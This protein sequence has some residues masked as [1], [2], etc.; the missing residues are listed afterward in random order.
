M[1][2]TLVMLLAI[3]M[4]LV[5]L[6]GCDG[7]KADSTTPTGSTGVTNSGNSVSKGTSK[8]TMVIRVNSDPTSFDPY[9]SGYGNSM[10]VTKSVFETLVNKDNEGNIK[11]GLATNWE[12]SEDGMSLTFK[13]REGVVFH[14]GEIFSADD[15][16]WSLS[17]FKTQL[18]ITETIFDFEN[19]KKISDYEISIP[20]KQPA[21]D[22]L[23]RL[24]DITYAISN[25]AAVEQAGE[26]YN[27]KP[28]GTG[29]FEFVSWVQGDEA[30]LKAFDKYWDGKPKIENLIMRVIPEDSQA[31][32]E[33]ELGNVDVVLA[34]N[35]TD[36]ERV[37]NGN[38]EGAAVGSY[39]DGN[40]WNLLFNYEKEWTL[41]KKLRQAISYAI[42]KEDIVNGAYN[43]YAAV[44]NQPMSRLF[45]GAYIEE[46]DA[47]NYSTYDPEKA[48]KLLSEAG[49]SPGELNLVIVTDLDGTIIDMAQLIKKNL[50]DVGIN[51]EIR[52]YDSA[53]AVGIFIA[54]DEDDVHMN[55]TLSGNGYPIV[56]L[57]FSDPNLSPN[58]DHAAD[59][60]L[61]DEV[62]K[63]YLKA[64]SSTDR[65]ECFSYVQ[66]GV[67]IEVEETLMVP[68]VET[69]NYYLYADNLESLGYINGRDFNF[70]DAYFK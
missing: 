48:K 59:S 30:K 53:T 43:G 29:P 35:L 70:K 16:I 60:G 63:N 55:I 68:L 20:L 40:V 1:K 49:Y 11:P 64:L 19:I 66:Q 10:V 8:D 24:C 47:S 62:Y 18:N 15:V 13:L 2:R 37:K 21:G 46:Y 44:A 56:Y 23:A 17:T 27:W 50:E 67:R 65:D 9:T 36:V 7:K 52:S 31:A 32:I 4:L 22:A 33:L 61:F 28:V 51:L 57:K 69:T 6:V 5:T 26:L 3:T 38:V 58:W 54:G 34:P 42:N 14:N 12:W 39:M 25:Q 45:P 41:N